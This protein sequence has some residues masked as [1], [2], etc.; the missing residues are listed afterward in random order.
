[1]SAKRIVITGLGILSSLGVGKDA[2]WNSLKGEKTGFRPLTVF[3]TQ[4]LK[5]NIAGEVTDFDPKKILGPAVNVRDLD[6]ATL[7]LS[8]ATRLCLDDAGI[9]ITADNT[10]DTGVSVGTTFGSLYSISEFDKEAIKDGPRYANP[11][12]FPS[13]VGNSPAS[14]I[15]IIFGVKGF[16]STISTGMSAALDAIDYARDFIQLGRAKTILCGSVEALSPQ[17]YLGF[18]KLNYLSGLTDGT[19]A[20]SRPFDKKRDGIIFSE[21]AVVMTVEE[22]E[23]AKARKANIY[24]EILGFGNSFD[25]S[26]FYRYNPA[27]TGMKQAMKNALVDAGLKKEDI[28]CIFANANSTKDADKIECAAINEV[29]DGHSGEVAVTAVKSQAGETYSASGQVALAAALGALAKGFIP[30]TVNLRNP[31]CNLDIVMSKP[32]LEKV[33]RV[34]VNAFGPN[35]ANTCMIIG[36]VGKV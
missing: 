36:A 29:F 3:D 4:G 19:E 30:A 6:R 28:D 25:Y 33:S 26:K 17:L 34:M 10:N 27:G 9:K 1:M 11:S 23:S 32:R 24:A 18:Y 21:A 14:R 31:D 16:N 2:F 8:S 5:T 35:G 15:S 7:L 12:V 20:I 13:T 22:L